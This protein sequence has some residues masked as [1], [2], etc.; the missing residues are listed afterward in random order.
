MKNALIGACCLLFCFIRSGL[1]VVLEITYQ[2][3]LVVAELHDMF[4]DFGPGGNDA[5]S[6][7][8]TN[9]CD[10]ELN[11]GLF[12]WLRA[13]LPFFLPLFYLGY[14]PVFFDVASHLI[15]EEA[16][17][18]SAYEFFNSKEAIAVAM[19]VVLPVL[20]FGAFCPEAC[21]FLSLWPLVWPHSL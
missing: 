14:P 12:V 5:S 7:S 1:Q 18:Y 15:S 6:D 11:R 16:T 10:L 3:Q 13:C 2:Y 19:Q 8:L 4:E 17:T 9:R 20:R 21:C